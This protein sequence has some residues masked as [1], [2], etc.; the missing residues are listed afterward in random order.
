MRIS[1]RRFLG[2]TALGTLAAGEAISAESGMNGELPKRTL[3]RTGA[4]VSILAM[5]GGSRFLMY[6]EEDKAL[7]ALNRAFDLGITYMDTAYG[8]GNGVSETRVGRVMAVRRKKD[9][10][11]L[12]TKINKRPGDEAM[13]II[14]GSLKRLQTDQVDLIH[15][16]SLTNEDDLRAIEAPDGVLNR[17]LKLR[18]QKVTRFIGIT[19][20]TD[21]TVLAAAL[22]R[23]DFDC[24]QMALNAA[25]AGMK[26]G[27]QGM[28]IN[29]AMKT[30]FETVALPVAVRKNL[31]IIA[32]KVHAQEG[33]SNQAPAEKLLYYSL[34]LPVSLAVVGMPTLDFIEQNVHLAKLFKPLAKSEMQELSARLAAKHK[35]ALDRRFANHV[36]A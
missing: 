7:E 6:K 10:I 12:A 22:E 30:S 24:T 16:H 21:P 25:L 15:I 17:L 20:H 1:R 14:E 36:D 3:G 27:N 28:E 26:D 13:R 11:F 8:Y 19:S 29:E 4:R 18:D 31:G 9:G 34:S 33:L 5:G 23:H 35:M 2:T 32:M